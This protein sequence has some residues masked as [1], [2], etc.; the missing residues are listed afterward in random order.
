MKSFSVNGRTAPLM[1]GILKHFRVG[2]TP[3][4][5]VLLLTPDPEIF[6]CKI[7]YR[8]FYVNSNGKAGCSQG[9]EHHFHTYENNMECSMKCCQCDHTVK[10]TVTEPVVPVATL[11]LLQK[12]RPDTSDFICCLET[13]TTYINNLLTGNSRTINVE[14]GAFKKRIKLDEASQNLFQALGFTLSDG[15]FH[16]P[17]LEMKRSSLIIAECELQVFVLNIRETAGLQ[18]PEQYRVYAD[19][20]AKILEFFGFKYLPSSE[21]QEY[22]IN[23]DLLG[24]HH[25][26]PDAV[27][28]WAYKKAVEH[29]P[30]S[31]PEYLDA[32]LNAAQTRKSDELSHAVQMERSQGRYSES[33]LRTAYAHFEAQDYSISDEDLIAVYSIHLSERPDKLEEH[34]EALRLIGQA[35]MSNQIHQFLST[36]KN[37]WMEDAVFESYIDNSPVGLDNIGNTCYLNSLLQY[38]FSIKSLRSAVIDS[39]E[40]CILDD[41]TQLGS[42]TTPQDAEN[43]QLFVKLLRDLFTTLLNTSE[44]SVAP[45]LE[46]ARIALTHGQTQPS[47]APAVTPFGPPTKEDAQSQP[48]EI[49]SEKTAEGVLIDIT[50]TQSDMDVDPVNDPAA[51]QNPPATVESQNVP[52]ASEDKPTAEENQV[53]TAAQHPT[54]PSLPPRPKS[55]NPSNEFGYQQDVTECMDNVMYLLDI[56]LS[57]DRTIEGTDG[58]LIRQLFFGKT[59]QTLSYVESATS[60][61]IVTKKEED[62][63]H[64]IVDVAQGRSLYDGLDEYFDNSKVAFNDTEAE[65]EVI[66][67]KLPPFLQIQVQRVQFDRTTSNVFKSNAYLHFEKRI[68]MDRYLA[69]NSGHLEVQKQAY[70]ALKAEITRHQ[71]TINHYMKNPDYP[72][73]IA[74]MLEITATYLKGEQNHLMEADGPESNSPSMEQMQMVAD[75]LMKAAQN[76]KEQIVRAEEKIKELQE[77][78]Q[79]IFDNLREHEYVLHAVFI[80]QGEASYGHYWIYIYDFDGSKWYK[81]NDVTVTEVAESEVLADT[82]NSTANP[83]CIVYVKA[84]EAQKLVETVTRK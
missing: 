48:E 6:V 79:L 60:Q 53:A 28:E 52:E 11:R 41:N 65:R 18:I 54:P 70:R 33:D 83:Y 34:R 13:F 50:P 20:T 58:S 55:E 37:D 69:E 23:Y 84:E 19:A 22:S 61:T 38:Y 44:R 9:P 43:A 31:I 30:S 35:R 27:V 1:F 73:P 82:T 63:S 71:N 45:S 62:F 40:P 80:H 57:R 25:D 4:N 42:V 56:A 24:V 2:S 10:F 47:N 5:H 72:I 21:S 78:A 67:T 8:F 17:Q 66:I 14:N 12:N 74:E 77:E 76:A 51:N 32:L 49:A 39:S 46:L 59:E 68:Y 3:H 15:H 26:A 64:L 36:G 7:C 81:Y 16:P 29:D 75:T